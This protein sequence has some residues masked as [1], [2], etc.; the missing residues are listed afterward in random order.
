MTKTY[1]ITTNQYIDKVSVGVGPNP[2]MKTIFWFR[3]ILN[4]ITIHKYEQ[5]TRDVY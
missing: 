1:E 3:K 2:L 5:Y 4:E